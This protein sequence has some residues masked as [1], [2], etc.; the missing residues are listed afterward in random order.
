MALVKN[1]AKDLA[2]NDL[3]LNVN[4]DSYVQKCINISVQ[5]WR[6]AKKDVDGMDESELGNFIAAISALDLAKSGSMTVRLSIKDY[7]ILKYAAKKQNTT[8]TSVIE[9]VVQEILK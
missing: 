9:K 1:D 4:T 8:M 2:D 7:A 6:Y 3:G 5:S